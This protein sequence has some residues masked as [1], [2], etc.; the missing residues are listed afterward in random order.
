M[1]YYREALNICGGQPLL[2]YVDATCFHG[3]HSGV[4]RNC[5]SKGVDHAVLMVAAGRTDAGVN[6]F[7]IKNSWGHKWGE[8]GYVRIEQ[9]QNWWGHLS[10][11]Y[12]KLCESNKGCDDKGLV[13][14][15]IELPSK[16]GAIFLRFAVLLLDRFFD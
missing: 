7:T 8:E 5:T 2:K 11:I 10:M 13:H 16:Q 6:Y 3:Y 14:Q 1:P 12:T 9:G 15:K 4:I